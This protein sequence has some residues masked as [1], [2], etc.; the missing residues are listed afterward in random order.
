MRS[1][2]KKLFENV[3]DKREKKR[4]FVIEANAEEML[5][6]K[7]IAPAARAWRNVFYIFC[8]WINVDHVLFLGKSLIFFFFPRMNEDFLS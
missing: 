5:L 3:I 1:K 6:F 7:I 2:K 4:Q 8:R